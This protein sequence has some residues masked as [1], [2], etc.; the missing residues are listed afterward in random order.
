[1]QIWPLLALWLAL[2]P[3]ELIRMRREERGLEARFGEE[4][5]VYRSSTWF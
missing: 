2:T 5:R 3:V 1:L 4:Y